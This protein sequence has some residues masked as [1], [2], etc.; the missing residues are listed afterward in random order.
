MSANLWVN[1]YYQLYCCFIWCSLKGLLLKRIVLMS[2]FCS[3][4]SSNSSNKPAQPV[5]KK[6]KPMQYYYLNHQL[7]SFIS[8]KQAR[9]RL[10]CRKSNLWSLPEERTGSDRFEPWKQLPKQD[11][12]NVEADVNYHCGHR[13]SISAI[14]MMG[15]YI[16]TDRT[17]Q[18]QGCS[19]IKRFFDFKLK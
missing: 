15:C 18:W 17:A 3:T 4:S 11:A 13:G 12:S 10:E 7:P 2:S 5:M 14:R 6:H 16:T 8:L 9:T 19:P 1:V